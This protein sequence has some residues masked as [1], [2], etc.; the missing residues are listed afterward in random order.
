MQTHLVGPVRASDE[1]GVVRGNDVDGA[2]ELRVQLPTPAFFSPFSSL[3]CYSNTHYSLSF[4]PIG[5][6]RDR[7]L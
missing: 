1:E 4:K 2:V 3:V 7:S 6:I 5:P